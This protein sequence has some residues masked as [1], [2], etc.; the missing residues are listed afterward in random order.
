M[1]EHDFRRPATSENRSDHA[2]PRAPERLRIGLA[3]AVATAMAVVVVAAGSATG[4]SGGLGLNQASDGGR[5]ARMW[6][7][8]GRKNKRWARRTSACESGGNA[9]IH[10]GGGVYHGAFQFLKSTWK[11]AP[12][13]PGGDPHR[14]SWKT[15]AVVAVYMKKRDGAGAWPNC[16]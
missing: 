4:D 7:N 9:K 12:K 3:A 6:E 13:S 1:N 5:Y 2:R 10:G 8:L 14:Y 16:G 15:Q 11:R